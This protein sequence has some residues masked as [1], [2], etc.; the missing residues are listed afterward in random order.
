MFSCRRRCGFFAPF[1]TGYGPRTKSLRRQS[2]F[3]VE[4]KRISGCVAW[5]LCQ[6][7][8]TKMAAELKSVTADVPLNGKNY[9]TRKVQCRMSLMKKALWNIVDGT[10]AAPGSENDRYTKFLARKNRALAIIAL[11]LERSLLYLIGD[12]EDP[13]TVW[14]KNVGQ[15]AGTEAKSFLFATE[16]W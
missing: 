12:P 11:S 9:P 15:Q 7:I 6:F 3:R 5:P 14:E 2:C 1:S 8:K 10:E 16:K 13:T 4:L